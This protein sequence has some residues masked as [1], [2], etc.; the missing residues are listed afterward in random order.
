M[1]LYIGYRFAIE[2]LEYVHLL[3]SFACVCLSVAKMIL[4][5]CLS[6]LEPSVIHDK[7]I[8]YSAYFPNFK[9]FRC[10]IIALIVK[11]VH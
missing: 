7:D 9:E 2:V 8:G 10:T 3:Q 1:R 5:I 11:R 6:S 4:F